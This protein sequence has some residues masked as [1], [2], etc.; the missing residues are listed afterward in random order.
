M[1]LNVIEPQF[2]VKRTELKSEVSTR[3]WTPQ[4]W[5]SVTNSFSYPTLAAVVWHTTCTN[6]QLS[7]QLKLDLYQPAT[8]FC[9]R[10][11][12]QR[13]CHRLHRAFSR[14]A[15]ICGKESKRLCFVV[16]LLFGTEDVLCSIKTFMKWVPLLYCS[17]TT[18]MQVPLGHVLNGSTYFRTF[19]SRPNYVSQCCRTEGYIFYLFDKLLKYNPLLSLLLIVQRSSLFW[20][21]R[22]TFHIQNCQFYHS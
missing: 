10:Y 13:S 8:F 20:L 6:R 22:P 16:F 17:N 5:V 15:T 4:T 2:G 14:Y 9:F 1:F 11:R 12:F 19:L 7:G 18:F 3:S 21:L